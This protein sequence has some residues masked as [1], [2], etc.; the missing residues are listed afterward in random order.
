MKM[1]SDRGI[2]LLVVLAALLCGLVLGEIM[3]EKTMLVVQASSRELE[4]AALQSA[5]GAMKLITYDMERAGYAEALPMK[6]PEIVVHFNER[7]RLEQADTGSMVFRSMDGRTTI[8]YTQEGSRLIRES[9]GREN[10][11]LI[12]LEHAKG[13]EAQ[14]LQNGR[15]VNLAFSIP[16]GRPQSGYT[17]EAPQYAHFIRSDSE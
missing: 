7:L 4:L 6:T 1:I 5:Q 17:P 15:V 3:T 14:Q 10:E 2:N 12:L 13:F 11:R 16:V 8:T 9:R